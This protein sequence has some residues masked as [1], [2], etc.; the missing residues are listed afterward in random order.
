MRLVIKHDGASISDGPCITR[1][2]GAV[3]A[4]ARASRAAPQGTIAVCSAVGTTTDSLVELV[5]RAARGDAAG[6]NSIVGEI[7]E[8]HKKIA[9]RT[10]PDES[11]RAR[12]MTELDSDIG[13]LAGLADGVTR[14]GD[15]TRRSTDYLLSFGERLAV[16]VFAHALA[17]TGTRAVAMTGGE[18]GILTDS[19][20][21]EARPLMD[22]TRLR[23]ARALGSHLGEGTVPVIGGFAGVDQ[24][25]HTTTLGRGG[26][27]YTATIIAACADADEVWMINE[28]GGLMSAD[29]EIVRD[30]APVASVSYVEAMEMS[31]FGARQMHPKTFEPLIGTRIRMVIARAAPAGQPARAGRRGIAR[32]VDM[33]SAT[34]VSASSARTIKCA[35]SLRH[36]ALIDI[37]GGSMVGEPGTAARIFGALADE[38]VNIMMISQNPSESSITVVVKRADL[39]RAVHTLEINLLGATIKSLDVVP[40]VAIVALVGSGMKGTIGVAARALGA[41]SKRRVNILMI[42]QGS[43]ELNLAFAVKEADSRAAVRALH[44]EFGLG[45]RQG[46]ARR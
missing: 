29:P 20:F 33:P 17:S 37:R 21:G 16:K 39:D 13:E 7:A 2:A 30:A 31:T 34:G 24:H 41:V 43:S 22:T 42:T 9:R 12:L 40:N 23:V 19:N 28:S 35:S 45:R 26:S 4:A 11:A 36:N 32:H 38:G 8:T 5:R 25:G 14:L 15:V 27:D 1:A 44:A 6:A 46:G 3:A 18:A 10:L